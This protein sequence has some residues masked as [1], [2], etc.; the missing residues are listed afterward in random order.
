M[1]ALKCPKCGSHNL[2]SYGQWDIVTD[3]FCEDCGWE[4]NYGSVGGF[5][6]SQYLERHE[7]DLGYNSEH[8]SWDM[9]L[10]PEDEDENLGFS[11]EDEE[12]VVVYSES[13]EP[14]KGNHLCVTGYA[15]YEES[16]DLPF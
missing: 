13:A 2:V 1:Y 11:E 15:D 12:H 9:D 14:A 5:A 6:G 8:D 16:D 10:G 3:H 4:K 7:N